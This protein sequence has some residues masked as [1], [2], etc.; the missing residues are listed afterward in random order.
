[1]PT[2]HLDALNLRLS[3][4][5][6]RLSQAKTKNEIE[7][8]TVWVQGIEKEIKSEIEF[9]KSKGIEVFISI[10]DIPDDDVLLAEL[11]S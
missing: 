6:V 3:N 1:M 8:R 11:L 2:S 5:R 10:D 7:L 9:L 4:E